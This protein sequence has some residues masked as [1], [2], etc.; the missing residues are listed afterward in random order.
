MVERLA[1]R[2]FNRIESDALPRDA[3]ESAYAMFESELA[4]I[5][6]KLGEGATISEDEFSYV[7]TFIGVLAVRNPGK[8]RSLKLVQQAI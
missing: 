1:Q 4:P 6:K 7:L 8:S 5:L 3:L 2:D